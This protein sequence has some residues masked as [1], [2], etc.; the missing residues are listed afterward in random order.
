M[1]E[2]LHRDGKHFSHGNDLEDMQDFLKTVPRD[3]LD[4]YVLDMF[5]KDQTVKQSDLYR[6][7]YAKIH[8]D[9][10]LMPKPVDKP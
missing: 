7:F 4:S 10:D 9:L 2:E 5:W 3:Q 8:H 1:A 6:A